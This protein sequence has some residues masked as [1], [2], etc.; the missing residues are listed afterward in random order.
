MKKLVELDDHEAV[1][2]MCALRYYEANHFT[3]NEVDLLVQRI[4]C[5][6]EPTQPWEIQRAHE[7]GVSLQ[8]QPRRGR[9]AE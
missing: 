3:A 5:P 7:N 8:R 1:L 6:D 9:Y 4:N 2:V